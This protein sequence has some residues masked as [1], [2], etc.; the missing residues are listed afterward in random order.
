MPRKPSPLILECFIAHKAGLGYLLGRC[1]PY[2]CSVTGLIRASQGFQEGQRSCGLFQSRGRR[3]HLVDTRFWW[4]H[5]GSGVAALHLFLAELTLQ[6]F[7]V[8]QLK[9]HLH[10]HGR[11]R[12]HRSLGNQ[13]VYRMPLQCLAQGKSCVQPILRSVCWSPIGQAWSLLHQTPHLIGVVSMPFVKILGF[14][15][16]FLPESVS[17]TPSCP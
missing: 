2:V 14:Y 16:L 4:A 15:Y 3:G 8:L 17:R 10:T 5:R 13:C 6:I 12:L 9:R 1:Q 11:G 7:S